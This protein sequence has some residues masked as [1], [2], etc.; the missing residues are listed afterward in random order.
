[1]IQTTK[2]VPRA[3]IHV[4]PVMNILRINVCLAIFQILD[5]LVQINVCALKVITIF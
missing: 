3:I 4:I 5:I 2:I 1:M